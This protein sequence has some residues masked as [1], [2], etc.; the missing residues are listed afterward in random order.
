[1]KCEK[2]KVWCPWPE[3]WK[4]TIGLIA[5]HFLVHFLAVDLHDCNVNS[6][7]REAGLKHKFKLEAWRLRI[8]RDTLILVFLNENCR[9]CIC[10]TEFYFV[11]WLLVVSLVILIA[12][13][14]HQH[15]S[16]HRYSA[17]AKAAMDKPFVTFL[18]WKDS[19]CLLET[20]LVIQIYDLEHD[21]RCER[22]TVFESEEWSSQ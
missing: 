9:L 3:L 2:L 7:H 18:K 13:W 5:A 1:M 12:V 15:K 8:F 4:T 10:F 11:C 22:H 6:K 21:S 16:E 14:W 20:S 19:F 17:L